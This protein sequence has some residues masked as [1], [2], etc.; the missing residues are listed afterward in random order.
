[1]SRPAPTLVLSL[2]SVWLSASLTSGPVSAQPRFTVAELPQTYVDL[3]DDTR[4]W[5]VHAVGLTADGRVCG[6]LRSTSAAEPRIFCLTGTGSFST[7]GND[8]YPSHGINLLGVSDRGNLTGSI[9]TDT[10]TDG[11]RAFVLDVTNL[12]ALGMIRPDTLTDDHM[13]RAVND[14]GGVAGMGASWGV[15]WNGEAPISLTSLDLPQVGGDDFVVH[16]V[17]DIN[18]SGTVVGWG[19]PPQGQNMQEIGFLYSGGVMI[20]I[21]PLD[22]GDKTKATAINDRGQVAVLSK[23]WVDSAYQ[24]TTFIYDTRV[25]PQDWVRIE[26]G[27]DMFYPIDMNEAGQIVGYSVEDEQSNSG[28]LMFWDGAQ[29]HDETDLG[30]DHLELWRPLALNDAGQIL[31]GRHLLTPEVVDDVDLAVSMTEMPAASVDGGG[32]ADAG[33]VR[34]DCRVDYQ[35]TVANLGNVDAVGVQLVVRLPLN[36]NYVVDPVVV[37]P[38]D[39]EPDYDIPP[40]EAGRVNCDLGALAA[41]QERVLG[42][43]FAIREDG[44]YTAE[45]SVTG[46]AEEANTGNNWASATVPGTSTCADEGDEADLSVALSSPDFPEGTIWEGNP[47]EPIAVHVAATNSGPLD[48]PE[49]TIEVT[50]NT[51]CHLK[52][53]ASV[54]EHGW[55]LLVDE[56]QRQLLAIEGSLRAGQRS[57]STV[58]VR[59][60]N[61]DATCTVTASIE[62]TI[63]D[64]DPSNNS[65]ELSWLYPPETEVCFGNSC[66]RSPYDELWLPAMVGLIMLRRTRGRGRGEGER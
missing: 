64:P 29:L 6:D 44:S 41:G 43:E 40:D 61:A 62:G 10:L 19:I 11:T 23:N 2:F 25:D 3:A 27:A 48:E 66:N 22:N 50:V 52:M 1:M 12:R 49:A 55:E 21:D 39:C 9:D 59:S 47:G 31:T 36:S 63:E 34:V 32:G 18:E 20:A 35:V 58:T 7:F 28:T 5:D 51:P 8:P 45:A 57:S 42:F 14:Q 37:L 56:P 15:I 26:T 60:Q 46:D 65:A 38:G 16:R 4:Q 17:A 13:G 53:S 30:I 24:Y 54:A 33:V